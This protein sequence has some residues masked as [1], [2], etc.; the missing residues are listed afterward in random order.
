MA[1]RASWTAALAAAL[2]PLAAGQGGAR[3]VPA[4]SLRLGMAL[5]GAGADFYLNFLELWVFDVNGRLMSING[6]N[7]VVAS[8]V[9]A[10]A[11]NSSLLGAGDFGA[12]I[13]NGFGQNPYTAWGGS[14]LSMGY[15]AGSPFPN[16]SYTLRFPATVLSQVM[17]LTRQD[18][19][20][21]INRPVIN[22]YTVNITH[23]NGTNL[24]AQT[25]WSNATVV[26]RTFSTGFN[27]PVLPDPNS[28]AQIAA[29]DSWVRYVRITLPSAN[30][31][32]IRE[33]MVF[34]STMTNVARNKSCTMSG[35]VRS[36]VASV[37]TTGC[38]RAV[39]HIIDF[40]NTGRGPGPVSP[41]LQRCRPVG[42]VGPGRHV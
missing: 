3:N 6:T 21:V 36:G 33:L 17:L 7:G 19:G 5:G 20:T 12:G 14:A 37:G 27:P 42:G 40:D 2:L 23:A 13:S 9:V 18:G 31:L 34:D 35:A 25:L 8:N 30:Y 22:R 16:A 39:D 38:D 29:R 32:H 10:T 26:T 15:H 4:S 24:E 11:F 41:H 1:P 28:P